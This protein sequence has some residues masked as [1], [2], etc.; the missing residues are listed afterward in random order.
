ML[1]TYHRALGIPYASGNIY[2][3][4]RPAFKLFNFFYIR[5]Y[6]LFDHVSDMVG[7][8]MLTIAGL[9]MALI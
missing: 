9:F 2:L 3:V 8:V 6:I 1:L 7:Y 5:T 4:F